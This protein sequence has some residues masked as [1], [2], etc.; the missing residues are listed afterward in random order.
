MEAVK[1]VAAEKKT[2]IRLEVPSSVTVML[3]D[4]D[5]TKQCVLNLLDNAMRYSPPEKEIVLRLTEEKE[6]LRIDVIDRD[7]GS[8]KARGEIS[9]ISFTAGNQR[10]K[11]G[12]RVPD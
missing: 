9:L 11:A 5:L 6:H 8:K 4:P 10:R 1:P 12:Q 3:I 2:N 7:T